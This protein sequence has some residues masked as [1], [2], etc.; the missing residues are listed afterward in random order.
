MHGMGPDDASPA[1]EHK[2]PAMSVI[3][4]G[5]R[6]RDQG[7]DRSVEPRSDA[8]ICLCTCNAF[9]GWWSRFGWFQLHLGVRAYLW[10]IAPGQGSAFRV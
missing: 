2:G 8:E 6:S 4:G 5:P 3:K 9:C 1:V 10:P 7:A